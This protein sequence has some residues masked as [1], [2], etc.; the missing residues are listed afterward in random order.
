M[1][2]RT[3]RVSLWLLVVL[4][5]LFVGLVGWSFRWAAVQREAAASLCSAIQLGMPRKLALRECE[6]VASE[7]AG[8]RY[9]SFPEACIV[10]TP[11]TIGARNWVVHI[12]FDHDVVVAVLV[13]TDDSG[14]IRPKDGPEDRIDPAFDAKSRF[15]HL[16]PWS[17]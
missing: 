10:G 4:G 12:L 11:T 5:V 16:V 15:P 7:H 17:D 1:L 3:D 6:S 9:D 14:S 8:W 2:S 13:R